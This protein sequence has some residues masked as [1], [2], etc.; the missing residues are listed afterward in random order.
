MFDSKFNSTVN[1]K[2][3][4]I[5]T[6]SSRLDQH[7]NPEFIRDILHERKLQAIQLYK[8]KLST[9]LRNPN[10]KSIHDI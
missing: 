6:D 4:H 8:N 2:T 10:L 9:A 7:S 5:N 3:S 1:F